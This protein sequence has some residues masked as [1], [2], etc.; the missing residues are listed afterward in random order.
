MILSSCSCYF[1]KY[2]KLNNANSI[3]TQ[4]ITNHLMEATKRLLKVCLIGAPNAGK[5]TLLNKLIMS[6]ISC[7]SNKVHTTRKNVLG[8]YTEA[9]T[10]LEFF[11]SPGVITRKHSLKHR[12]EDS[13]LRDPEEAAA[14]CDLIALIVDVSN[15][16][17]SWKLN[18]NLLNILN[19][20]KDKK[21]LLVMN[22]V[23]LV[24]DKRLLLDIGMR[25]TEGHIENELT[26]P[27]EQFEHM[28][29]RHSM[30]EPLGLDPDRPLG[31]H[32]IELSPRKKKPEVEEK[33]RDQQQPS[34]GYRN[35]SRIFSI[36]A[37]NDDGVDEL[38]QELIQRAKPV[39]MWPHGPNYMTDMRFDDIVHSIIRGKMMDN[40][41]NEVP[42]V[43]K[44]R[45]QECKFDELG[46]LH[47]NL[48]LIA[49]KKY[50]IGQI[51]GEKG[52]II[53]SVI[54]ESRDLIARTLGCDVK[55]NIAVVAAN[56][57]GS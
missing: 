33:D 11:D 48:Q 31:R 8:V 45:Y 23:D 5:S 42:Y 36:S 37:L 56:S 19:D 12:L 35:F 25:L 57:P 40:V 16:R 24:K 21:S 20:H 52:S 30:N 29:V 7:V 27:R 28:M 41:K 15:K 49:P 9:D 38:R 43:L 13:L 22:K 34:I 51:L 3:M 4:T 6:E 32:V 54:N 14:S 53:F 50:M 17:D 10:Q 44:Y 39:E 26:C 55:L 47:V 1:T 2:E 18:R 46:S